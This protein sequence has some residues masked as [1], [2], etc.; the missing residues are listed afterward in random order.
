[1]AW[2]SGKVILFGEHAVVYG[3]PAIAAGIDKG[4]SAVAAPATTRSLVVGE[5]EVEGGSELALAYAA[6]LEALSAPPLATRLTVE[7]PPGCGL[8]ASAAMGVA[9]ARAVLEATE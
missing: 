9:C 6:L 7:L 1:M 2:A 4:V 8:G 5:R 3:V